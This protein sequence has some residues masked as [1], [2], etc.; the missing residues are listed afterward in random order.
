MDR[1]EFL[2]A[3][4]S[5]AVGSA[6]FADEPAKTEPGKGA[7]RRGLRVL[8]I[9]YEVWG[10]A[11][12]PTEPILATCGS[13]R[14]D[15]TFS[16]YRE[17][18][19]QNRVPKGPSALALWDVRTLKRL[20]GLDGGSECW[21]V[22]FSTD[23]KKVAA[24]RGGRGVRIWDVLSG[25]EIVTLADRRETGDVQ[26]RS[27]GF[28]H[29]DEW[30][31]CSGTEG[32]RVWDV[33]SESLLHRL[34]YRQST[35]VVAIPPHG[36]ALV[37]GGAGSQLAVWMATRGELN[38]LI[39]VD[40]KEIHDAVFSMDGNLLGIV[41]NAG[42]ARILDAE[43]FEEKWRMKVARC[44][45]I[46]FSPRRSI[47]AFGG[48]RIQLY[49]LRSRAQLAELDGNTTGI[50]RLAFSADGKLLATTSPDLVLN[51]WDMDEVLS[52]KS[53]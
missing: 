13:A 40:A 11:F 8:P 45:S 38:Q 30:L 4:A 42:I 9:G 53:E 48:E 20:K 51:L 43:L 33:Q 46:A 29:N 22:A 49:D 16:G 10:L 19:R 18:Q 37:G 6:L 23:G 52:V 28:M 14:L 34:D 36:V 31:V 17:R 39:K 7:T 27:I 35:A 2:A 1:R 32:V 25:E 26:H 44:A 21:S 3:S 41:D 50:Q 5:M 12:S 47:V 24:G 15:Y